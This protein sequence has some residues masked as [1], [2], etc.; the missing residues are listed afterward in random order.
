MVP[1]Q[2]DGYL[3]RTTIVKMNLILDIHICSPVTDFG[4]TFVLGKFQDRVVIV[5][6]NSDRLLVFVHKIA[7]RRRRN[8]VVWSISERGTRFSYGIIQCELFYVFRRGV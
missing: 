6:V 3:R 8:I 7:V 4:S 5:K 2:S 1:Q